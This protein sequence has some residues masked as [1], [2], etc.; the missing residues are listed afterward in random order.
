MRD[1]G[2]A[3]GT[4][5]GGTHLL[6]MASYVCL[7]IICFAVSYWSGGGGEGSLSS[8]FLRRIINNGH[9]VSTDVVSCEGTRLGIYP[10]V[11]TAH[12]MRAQPMARA[13]GILLLR[14]IAYNIH[15]PLRAIFFLG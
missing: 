11:R 5:P 3:R 8:R 10:W 9:T 13:G 14:T 15:M 4:C 6:L 7:V 1:A 2:E 12:M